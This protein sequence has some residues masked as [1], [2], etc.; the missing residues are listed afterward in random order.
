MQARPFQLVLLTSLM[1]LL[2]T[3]CLLGREGTGD[4]VN[5]VAPGGGSGGEGGKS[6]CGN[7]YLNEGED[8]DQA[9]NGASCASLGFPGGILGCNLDTCKFDTSGCE[10]CG[11]GTKG[12][13]E[14]C[15]GALPVDL[16]CE[17]LVKAGTPQSC[18]PVSC[19]VV[20]CYP[21]YFQGFEDTAVMPTEL[22]AGGQ[23]GWV[24]TT[25][26]V[27]GG[28]QAAQ[29]GAIDDSQFSDMT[30][31]LT[32]DQPGQISFYHL[33]SAY[34]F[35]YLRF[36]VD[37]IQQGAWSGRA[38]GWAEDYYAVGLGQH[39]FIWRYARENPGSGG[40]DAI[41]V[42]NIQAYNGYLPP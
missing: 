34:E 27:C 5:T 28:D 25:E 12:V 41:Y 35:D 36:F 6:T 30:L 8:C 31:T 15:D 40:A 21:H 11:N 42:D 2:G 20:G 14:E 38:A 29:S 22:G 3:T 7:G 16:I 37:D 4:S 24:L 26:N 39:R 19:Q 17:D 13:G 23:A 33:E 10:V 32:Y 1:V 18:D 9:L